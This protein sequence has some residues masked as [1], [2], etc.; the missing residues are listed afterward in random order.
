M[1]VCNKNLLAQLDALSEVVEKYKT[2]IGILTVNI[3]D[4]R[5]E[6]DALFKEILLPNSFQD[7]IEAV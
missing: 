5:E 7:G 3:S 2:E 1:E 6:N 4:M